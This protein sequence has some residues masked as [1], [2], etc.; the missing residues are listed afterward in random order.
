MREFE[1]PNQRLYLF[2]AGIDLALINADTYIGENW[3][4]NCEGSLTELTIAE[5]LNDEEIYKTAFKQ[6]TMI[7]S[8]QIFMGKMARGWR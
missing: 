3:N 2:E 6:Q 8:E 4:G 7:G 1:A 5:L